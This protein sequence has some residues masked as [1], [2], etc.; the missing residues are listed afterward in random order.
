[1]KTVSTILGNVIVS[2][3]KIVRASGYGQYLILIDIEFNGTKETISRHSTDS[4][5]FDKATDEDVDHSEYVLHHA[6]YIIESA[7]EDYISSL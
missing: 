6:N 4:I 2:D 1:M 7:V 5:L 3:A